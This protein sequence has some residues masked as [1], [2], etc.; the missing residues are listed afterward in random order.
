VFIIESDNFSVDCYLLLKHLDKGAFL[1]DEV[2]SAN[3]LGMMYQTDPPL[4]PK[5]DKA[6]RSSYEDRWQM[7]EGKNT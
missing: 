3:L 4:D 6:D 1:Y 2:D 5:R 7:A